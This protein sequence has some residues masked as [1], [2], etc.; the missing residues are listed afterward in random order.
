M[1]HFKDE[2]KVRNLIVEHESVSEHTYSGR[3]FYSLLLV[4]T[5]PHNGHEYGVYDS[6]RTSLFK[7]KQTMLYWGP[8]EY[9]F[10]YMKGSYG[11]KDG[12]ESYIR[13]GLKAVPIK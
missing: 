10:I 7:A 13:V 11:N 6:I 1:D 5:A 2:L 3:R 12:D 8:Y 4:D 9:S